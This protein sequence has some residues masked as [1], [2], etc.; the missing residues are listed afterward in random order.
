MSGHE[1]H[2]E[3]LRQKLAGEEVDAL[4]VGSAANIR[5]LSGFTGEGY[6]VVGTA[7]LAVAT[8]GRYKVEAEDTV[9]GCEACFHGAGHLPGAVDFL[10]RAGARIVAFE[11][12]FLTYSRFQDLA[13]KLPKAEL[14]P[15]K[16][17]V[18]EL[19]LVKDDAEIAAI[20]EAA[21]RTDAALAQFLADVSPGQTERQLSLELQLAMAAQGTHPSFEVIMA[22]GPSSA[23][24]HWVPGS[25]PLA[26]GDMLKIDVGGVY[27]GYCSDLTRTYFIGEPPDKFREVYSLVKEA[28]AAAVAA[29]APGR[30]G[31]E[32]DEVARTIITER[33][34]GDQFSHGLGHGVGLEVHEGPRV[35]SRSEDVLQPGMVVT[36]EPGVYLPGWGGVRIEDLVL[37]TA[38][39]HELLTR[40][41]I[42]DYR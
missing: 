31:R 19:R 40:A 14:R 22:S 3:A 32:I 36:I 23:S 5:Y 41:P 15:V 9:P 17:W 37:V 11:A 30:T 2:L 18:E 28:Q 27:E 16:G 8:D 4:L 34:Y 29:V 39:G 10:E 6:A 13:K 26:E 20:R 38:D 7:Q 12:D 42:P 33:G 21:R 24:P 1:A 35:S 25:R